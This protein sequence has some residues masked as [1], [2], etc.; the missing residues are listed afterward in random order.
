MAIRVLQG[1]PDRVRR[2]IDVEHQ[3]HALVFAH[4]AIKPA[5]GSAVI[6]EGP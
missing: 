4:G 3:L 1:P 5:P 6:T 2:R